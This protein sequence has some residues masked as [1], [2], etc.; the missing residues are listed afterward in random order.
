[1][2]W[3]QVSEEVLTVLRQAFSH[4]IMRTAPRNTYDRP[5]MLFL[6]RTLF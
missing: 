6:Q 4:R 1:M 3:V 2:G 5:L